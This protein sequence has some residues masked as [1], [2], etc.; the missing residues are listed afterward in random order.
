MNK[1]ITVLKGDG[2]GPEIVDEALKVLDRIGEKYGHTF[3]KDFVDIGGASIDKYGVP[4]T[5]EGLERCKNCDSVLLGAVGGPKCQSRA[6]PFRE[7][8]PD[9]DVRSA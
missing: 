2:I 1:K 8:S 4:I 3:E 6:R 5:D 9:K 7:P